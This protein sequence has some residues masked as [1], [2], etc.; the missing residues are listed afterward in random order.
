MQ[1]NNKKLLILGGNPETIPLVLVAQKMGIQVYLTDD[2]PNSSAK[3]FANKSFNVNG[4]DVEGI[5]KLA[6]NENLDGVLVGVADI[7]V[8]SYVKVCEALN[9][10]C[11]ATEELSNI[12][13]HKDFFKQKIKEFDIYGISEFYL[14][15]ELSN[16]DLI[17]IQYPV[18]VKP[19]DNGGGV[20]MTCCYNE[21]EIKIAVTKALSASKRSKFLVERYM[22]CDDVGV[23]YTFQDGIC[24][25]SLIYDRYTT[26]EQHGVSRVCLGGTYP[27]KHI[28]T[29]L[30][31]TDKN[32]KKMFNALGVKNGVLMLS[33]FFENGEF[34]FYDP[35]FR[36][37][38]ESPNLFLDYFHGYDQREQL[39][40]FALTGSMGEKK[41]YELDDPFLNGK[42]ASTLW[43]LLKEGQIK[44]TQGF[45][46]LHNN[47]NIIEVI[48]RL[49]VGDLITK[50]IIGTEKQVFCR[51]YIAASS[52]NELSSV[53]KSLQT[54]LKVISTDNT[55]MVL[56]GFDVDQVLI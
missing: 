2:N 10:P 55:N 13:S 45:E 51:I 18:M 17:K 22:E 31:K 19:V 14:T 16:Q 37:Q 9:F 41:A 24:S 38:G 11:Y 3:K 33:A 46:I 56:K 5:I 23:Y 28:D 32:L 30:N 12:F 48:T 50:E 34:Y 35:G 29:F 39:I 20:G 44:E 53:L 26:G 42:Y 54:N 4:L 21:S 36:L 15:S 47:P 49:K 6:I 43:I 52:K 8:K 7:L 27:S 25:T 1:F 40:T